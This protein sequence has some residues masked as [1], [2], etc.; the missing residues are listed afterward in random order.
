VS[1][2]VVI[3]IFDEA[4]TIARVVRAAQRHAR[5]LVVDD[6][7]T[8]ASARE[9]T[10]A[11]AEVLRHARR[12]GKGQALRTGITAARQRGASLIATL[13]GDGQH[14]PDDLPRLLA[15]AR[16]RAHAIVIG[17]RLATRA[18]AAALPR[19]RLV[20]IRVAG[21]FIGWTSGLRVIDTQS[22]F[23]V[24]RASCLDTIRPRR[25]GFV[26]ETEVLLAAARAGLEVGEVPITALP[27]AGRRSRFRPLFDGTAI[28]AFLAG[29]VLVRC[30]LEARAALRDL[31]VRRDRGQRRAPDRRAGERS[32]ATWRA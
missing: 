29:R 27:R 25:G 1:V 10:A 21:F 8:D 15:A 28:G 6:G 26:F 4:A 18:A 13:D 3:P 32:V 22:G 9:A 16:E 2:W 17:N 24:Y 11:G 19:G 7:S 23:R 31:R 5:V 12:L 14:D 20:A 30:V